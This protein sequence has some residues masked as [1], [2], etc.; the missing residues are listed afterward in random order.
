MSQALFPPTPARARAGT[1]APRLR[2]AQPGLLA[3]DA[4]CSWA[5]VAGHR[6]LAIERRSAQPRRRAAKIRRS[7]LRARRPAR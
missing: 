7:S 1:I 5:C 4:A 6:R 2:V 3:P